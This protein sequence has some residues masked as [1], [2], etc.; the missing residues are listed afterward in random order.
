MQRRDV[1][2]SA[3]AGAAVLS[4]P[5]IA[6][7]QAKNV[8]RFVPH[9]DP[10]SLDPVWTTA[11]ITRNYSL[12]VFDTLYG[13]DA[14]LQPRLQMLASEKIENDGKL[15]E[16][17]LRDGL[18]FHDGTPVLASDC[19]ASIRR[20]AQRDPLMNVMAQRLDEISA[21]SDKV[22]RIKLKRAF[23]LL[24]D[25]LTGAPASIMPERVAKA[26]GNTQ[27]SEVIGSGPFRF[28][29]NERVPGA[30]IVFAK[31]DGYVPRADGTA[32]FTA[33]PKIANFERVE[34]HILPDAAT[35]SAALS[36][37]EIDWW[38]NPSIDLLPSLKRD[39]SLVTKTIDPYGS[40]GCLRFNHLNAP[41]DKAAVRRAVLSAVNQDEFMLAY[42]GAEPSIIKNPCGLFSSGSP[43]ASNVGTEAVGRLS[44]NL[45]QVKKDLAAA[46]YNGEKVVL[47]G[48]TTIPVLHA[49]SQLTADLLARIGM[50]VDYVA[51]EW[52]TVVQRRASKEPISKG[53]WNI[54]MTNLGGSGNVSPAAASAIRSGQAAWFGWPDMPAMEALRENWLDAGDV[55]TQKSIA[56]DMQKL[57]FQEAPYV[58][59]GYYAG[60]TIYRNSITDIRDGFP[61]MY[62]VK[63]V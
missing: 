3:F 49:Y 44:K 13:L 61:Q 2:K 26:D 38:E 28:L 11:D 6:T 19:V 37:N 30:K 32:S 42:A 29:T 31:F 21:P 39:K 16:L 8:L 34:W 54:F 43:L 58:P 24:R 50:N 53:G 4:T 14:Q 20:G 36:N 59:L 5:H 46:G 7:G 63:R 55:A 56:L 33:G 10:V 51:V 27:I 45:D 35:I 22:I 18:K 23:P 12:A 47:L 62:G 40:I 1:L 48:P 41:F 25:A 52:G 60:P 17:T 15:W 57:L 9:A